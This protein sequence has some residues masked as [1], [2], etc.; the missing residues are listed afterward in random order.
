MKMAM[1]DMGMRQNR[2]LI[3]PVYKIHK[4]PKGP[5]LMISV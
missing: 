1:V 2:D 5:L 4:A 3:A